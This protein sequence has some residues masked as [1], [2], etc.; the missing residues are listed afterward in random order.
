[1]KKEWLA[2]QKS[3]IR[4][5]NGGL[6]LLA[7]VLALLWYF[8]GPPPLTK[9]ELSL[10]EK[11]KTAQEALFAE[12]SAL[13]IEAPREVDP[14]RT[15]FPGVEWSS[16][17][18]TLGPL[19]AK[20][21]AAD[22]LWSVYALRTFRRLGLKPGD[23]V[24]VFSSSSFPGLVFSLL[25]A[26][27]S[28]KL[29]VLWIHSLGSSTWGANVAEFPWPRIAMTLREKGFLSI[30]ADRYTLGGGG[31][32]GG[33]MPPEG[34]ALLREAAA[35]EGIPLVEGDSLPE[36]IERKT[37]LLRNF[38]PRLVITVGGSAA[39]FGTGEEEFPSGG[40]YRPDERDKYP[41]A[42]VF[43][44]ALEGG[45]PVLHFLNLRSLARK[46]G[47]P[48]DGRPVPGFSPGGG[49]VFSAIGLLLFMTVLYFFPRWKKQ[50]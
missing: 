2:A 49:T 11:V 14:W 30:K 19:E 24:A 10:W 21:T 22:P 6:V 34:R 45:I 39:T 41:G 42:G 28:L 8:S 9:E 44:K 23:R 16:I 33:G 3:F 29:S 50:A 17:T 12:R 43:Q 15:G 32:M 48:Y 4:K 40:Y 20:R 18:T 25:S 13:R 35:R 5:I 37:N 36:I 31:E 38:S 27:D 26:A 7:L 47:I 46:A 1:M